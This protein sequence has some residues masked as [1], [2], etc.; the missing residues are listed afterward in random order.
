MAV[1][2]FSALSDGQAF[3]RNFFW[4]VDPPIKATDLA[5]DRLVVKSTALGR[6]RIGSAARILQAP[7]DGSAWRAT[8]VVRCRRQCPLT[9]HTAPRKLRT[10]TGEVGDVD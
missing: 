7:A 5:P 8:A 10:V 4:N 6:G 9:V 2:Q 1:F 3:S